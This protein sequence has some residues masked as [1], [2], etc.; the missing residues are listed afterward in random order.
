MCFKDCMGEFSDLGKRFAK[1]LKDNGIGINKAGKIVG[2]TGGQISN[3]C[4]GKVFGADKMFNILNTFED[5]DANYLF[6]GTNF[7]DGNTPIDYNKEIN[8]EALYNERTE[9][10]NLYREK[11]IRLEL[12]NE[13]LKKIAQHNVAP[14]KLNKT[15]KDI[16]K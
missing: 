4:N 5:L 15:N 2:E 6:R 14:L 8:Y 1:Y 12:E 10:I 9:L 7:I 13:S 16:E 11:I 3:I